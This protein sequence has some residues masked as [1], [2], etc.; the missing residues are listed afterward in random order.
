MNIF[1]LRDHVINNYHQYV[2]SSLN[3][4]NERGSLILPKCLA[5]EFETKLYAL[6]GHL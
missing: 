3:I 1:N 4:R 6:I 5:G 2:E